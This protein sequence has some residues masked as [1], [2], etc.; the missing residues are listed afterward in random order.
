MISTIIF[1]ALTYDL[2]I[3]K[4]KLLTVK[5]MNYFTMSYTCSIRTLFSIVNSSN[6]IVVS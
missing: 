3:S 1:L 6:I 2:Y 5:Y 4:L